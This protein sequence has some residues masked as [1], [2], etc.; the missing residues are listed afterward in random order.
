MSDSLIDVERV[1]NELKLQKAKLNG[2]ELT[3]CCPNPNHDDR[4]PSWS[5]NIQSQFYNCWSCGFSG[6]GLASLYLK[7]GFDIPEW[8]SGLPEI[9]KKKR[10]RMAPK[11]EPVPVEIRTSWLSW[12]SAN[13]YDA[14]MKLKDRGI[15]KKAIKA[16][17][18]GYNARHDIL[19]FPCLD[20]EGELSGWAERSDNWPNRYRLM[21]EG[22][23]RD[24]LIFGAHLIKHT[25]RNVI[26][27]VEGPVDCMKMWQ[28]G[29]KSVA[30]N[31][32]VLFDYQAEWLIDNAYHVIAIPDNDKAGLKLRYDIV[33][34]LKDKVRLSGVNLPEDINDVGDAACTK[35]II[36]AAIKARIKI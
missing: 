27:L 6:K 29:F 15:T 33:D 4:N 34:K 5:F 11:A 3:A 28:W 10:K 35:E 30:L 2:D 31:G 8:V 16:F 24:K 20:S 21:P 25:E 23:N 32:S 19:F 12:L 18:I 1:I 9:K 17:N 14:Y 13:P 36:E 26:Y 22:V 7:L